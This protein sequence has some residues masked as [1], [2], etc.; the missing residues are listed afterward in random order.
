[1][2]SNN[3]VN[4]KC[5]KWINHRHWWLNGYPSLLSLPA[6]TNRLHIKMP[7]TTSPTAVSM[8]YWLLE[9]LEH[10]RKPA[11]CR[12]FYRR[13]RGFYQ[14]LISHSQSSPLINAGCWAHKS[15][16]SPCVCICMCCCWPM[17]VWYTTTNETH[18]KERERE[19]ERWREREFYAGLDKPTECSLV[20][21][22]T[23]G[24][25]SEL[26]WAGLSFCW[27]GERRERVA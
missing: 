11:Y 7:S 5:T 22:L 13:P 3:A 16:I 4:L 8:K 20:T 14:T 19:R 2:I 15:L 26:V 10:T 24:S 1:M 6:G 9:R 27:E 23:A 12:G 18:P 17:Y 21:V 25:C